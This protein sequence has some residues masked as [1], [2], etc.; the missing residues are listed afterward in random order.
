MD[1]T[2][3]WQEHPLWVT[4]FC[5]DRPRPE[6]SMRSTWSSS[7]LSALPCSFHR[8]KPKWNWNTGIVLDVKRKRKQ[9]K[10]TASSQQ[11]NSLSLTTPSIFFPVRRIH[12]IRPL[13]S[14]GPSP[15]LHQSLAPYAPASFQISALLL[16]G[17]RKGGDPNQILATPLLHPNTGRVE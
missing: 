5:C 17:R 6:S 11:T 1:K 13:L 2:Q 14:H 8:T 16:D 3:I 4:E 10:F 7:G 9:S 12:P 15:L